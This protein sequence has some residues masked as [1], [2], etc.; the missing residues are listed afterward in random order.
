MKYTISDDDGM[1]AL[2]NVGLYPAFVSEDCDNE[3]LK[4]H[5]MEEMKKHHIIIWQTSNDGG[6]TWNIDVLEKPSALKRYREFEK[7]IEVTTGE[8]FIAS[9]NDLLTM[10]QL[11][12]EKLP[13]GHHEDLSIKLDNG[14]YKVTVRQMFDPD[15]METFSDTNASFEL[16][17]TQTGITEPIHIKDIYWAG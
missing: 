4:P 8:L 16:I 10:A 5:L 2:V 6:G 13:A 3:K 12:E 1:I 11:Q 17:F 9:F 7:E 14:F 15:D